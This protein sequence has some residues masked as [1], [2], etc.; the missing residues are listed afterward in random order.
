MYKEEKDKILNQKVTLMLKVT[1][2]CKE[3]TNAYGPHTGPINIWQTPNSISL[4]SC[5][6]SS[7]FPMN[8]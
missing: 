6:F 4:E 1:F 3:R 7:F 5:P 2:G 8:K